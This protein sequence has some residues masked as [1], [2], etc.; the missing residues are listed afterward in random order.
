M[1]QVISVIGGAGHV[2]LPLCLVLAN[3]NYHVYGIDTDNVKN[4]IIMSGKLPF[5]EEQGEVYLG[6]ALD[7]NKLLMTSDASKIKESDIVIIVLGT[8]TD[9]NLN[10]RISPL[11]Q[12]INS[13]KK[14]LKKGQLIILRSTVTPGTTE[15]I[16][17]LLEE[18]LNYVIGKDIFL[19]YAPERVFQ[20]KAINELQTLPQLIGA[21]DDKSYEL[22]EK[23]FSTFLK[24]KCLRMTPTEAEIGKLI[25]NMARYVEF[26]VANEF[27]LIADQFGVNINK[28]IDSCSYNYPRLNI[29]RPG[30]NV[31]GP[32]LYKDGW[33]LLERLPFHGIISTAFRVN[34]GMTMQIV[35]KLCQVPHIK[36]VAILGLT[37]K[38]GSDD[39]RNSL[40]FKLKKQLE[41]THNLILID[42]H[43][44]GYKDI[45]RIRGSDAVV[46]MTPHEEFSNL[47]PLMD[48]V[49]NEECLYVDIWGFWEVMK[50]K[51]RN[52]YFWGKEA[53]LEYSS[54]R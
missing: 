13:N 43:L 45:E 24:D 16:K 18:D 44:T 22:A 9:E 14:F 19:V 6:K 2:G 26:A 11:T 15:I 39:I 20:G 31:G 41:H 29:P 40:S 34:E 17:H 5:I 28:I 8:P 42:P 23:F 35:L 53:R 30:P 27:Y 54:L 12:M 38:A 50:H 4:E 33:F 48:L 37:Y 3:C 7:K 36:K 10:P 25:T 1:R 32:C 51:S 49:A 52:G 21:Y 47:E 46:L